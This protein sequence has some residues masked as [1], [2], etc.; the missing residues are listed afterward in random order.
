[1]NDYDGVRIVMSLEEWICRWKNGYIVDCV[2][3]LLDDSVYVF[4]LTNLNP[5]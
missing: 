4:S 3:V 1:M 2:T 5:V